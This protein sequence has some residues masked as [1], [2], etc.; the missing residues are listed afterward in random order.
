MPILTGIDFFIQAT[1]GGG[2]GGGPFSP[3]TETYTSGSGTSTV[4]AAAQLVAEAYGTGGDGGQRASTTGHGGG[5]GSGA[6]CKKTFV[7]VAGDIGKTIT[8]DTT[9]ATVVGDAAATNLTNT[10]LNLSAG[11][12]TD[13]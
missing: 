4:P 10:A 11:N 5:G 12:G 2:T 13:G 1:P 3:Y 9:G 8:W 7:V 6:Y